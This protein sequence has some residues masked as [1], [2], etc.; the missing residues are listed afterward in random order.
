MPSTLKF[1]QDFKNMI[2]CVD[3]DFNITIW[4][5]YIFNVQKL[6][7]SQNLSMIVKIDF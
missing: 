2:F 5:F 7:K 1:Y 4:I 3:Y 6:K